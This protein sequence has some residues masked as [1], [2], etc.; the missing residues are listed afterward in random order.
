[1]NGCMDGQPEEQKE[2]WVGLMTQKETSRGIIT[3]SVV[4]H[5]VQL[6]SDCL[7]TIAL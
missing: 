1:M 7:V 4:C 6:I 2:E 5:S 3:H